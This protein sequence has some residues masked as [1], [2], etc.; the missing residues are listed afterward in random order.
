MSSLK[1]TAFLDDRQV[2]ETIFLS[3]VTGFKVDPLRIFRRRQELLIDLKCIENAVTSPRKCSNDSLWGKV[4]GALESQTTKIISILGDAHVGKTTFLKHLTKTIAQRE[5]GRFKGQFITCYL[6]VLAVMRRQGSSGQ[7]EPAQLVD[8]L[9][10]A[11][12]KL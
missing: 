10:A 6:D 4:Q 1:C 12:K 9:K 8:E 3:N 2:I 11:H 7:L 5:V